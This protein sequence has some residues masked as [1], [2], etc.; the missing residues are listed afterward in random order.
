M[1]FGAGLVA[2]PSRCMVRGLSPLTNRIKNRRRSCLTLG[3]RNLTTLL[4]I[5]IQVMVSRTNAPFVN[6]VS[7]VSEEPRFGNLDARYHAFSTRRAQLD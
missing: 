7:T 5:R 6:T 4:I 1:I 2:K 3:L